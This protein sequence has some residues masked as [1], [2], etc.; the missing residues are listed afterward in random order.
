MAKTFDKVDP[1][2][3]YSPSLTSVS[4]INWFASYLINHVQQVRNC[5][6]RPTVTSLKVCL[7]IPSWAGLVLHLNKRCGPGYRCLQDTP[8]CWWYHHRLIW[9]FTPLCLFVPPTH[10]LHLCLCIPVLYLNPKQQSHLRPSMLQLGTGNHPLFRI[11]RS[12]GSRLTVFQVL[13]PLWPKLRP[14]WASSPGII[15]ISQS[16]PITL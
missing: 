4:C 10:V 14:D 7:K 1:T 12:L 16:L 13:I 9:P 8:L 6:V 5:G 3:L 11:A 15:S 2:S